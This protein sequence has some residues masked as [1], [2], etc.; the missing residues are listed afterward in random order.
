MYYNT[1]MKLIAQ[2]KLQPTKEQSASLRKT[3]LAANGAAL[4]VS[5]H[6]WMAKTFGQ[7][8]LH[9][10]LY[11]VIREKFELS[12]QMA[13]RVIAKVADSYKL[14][15]KAKRTFAKLG[16]IAYDSRI[17][18]WKD[19]QVVSLWSLAGRLKMPYLAG[20]KQLDLLQHAQGEADLVFRKGEWYIL[21]TCDIPE[22]EGFDPDE[23]LGVDSGLV[24]IAVDSDGN[25][26]DGATMLSMRKRRRRQRARLQTKQTKSAKRVLRHLSKKEQRYASN[27]NHRIS[28]EIVKLAKCTGRGIAVEDLGGIRDSVKLRR[29]QRTDLHSWSFHQLHS[30]LSYKAKLH[31]VPFKKIDP[32]NTSR[33]C[34]CCGY[35]DKSNRKSQDSF[36]CGQ[37]GFAAHADHNAA[38]NISVVGRGVVNRPH[39]SVTDVDFYQLSGSSQRA[40][41]VGI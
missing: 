21:Q 27:E 31:G 4:F 24:N 11:Y 36:L 2:V 34:S 5:D 40:L 32:R 7:Y 16:S 38:I 25:F 37:C 1:A 20:Q 13:V 3:L 9:H 30:F 6:A 35:I 12:S 28:K 33:T 22:P 23:W 8:D 14:D 26:H 41:A 15:K 29:K 39:E 10:A 18:T 17:L 19:N